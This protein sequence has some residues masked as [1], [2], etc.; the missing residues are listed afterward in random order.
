V[1]LSGQC[2]PLESVCPSSHYLERK[3]AVLSLQ[4]LND[5]LKGSGRGLFQSAVPAFA[6]VEAVFSVRGSDSPQ[7]TSCRAELCSAEFDRGVS[8]ALQRVPGQ[9]LPRALPH[10]SR[11]LPVH[12]SRPAATAYPM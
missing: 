3:E 10:P 6:S 8:Q 11:C 1:C 9:Y 12:C 5:E 4:L 7:G 2:E